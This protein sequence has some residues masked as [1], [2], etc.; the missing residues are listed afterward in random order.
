MVCYTLSKHVKTRSMSNHFLRI[1]R[2]DFKIIDEAFAEDVLY[3]K[4][5]GDFEEDEIMELYDKIS[6]YFLPKEEIKLA[7][8]TLKL[9]GLENMSKSDITPIVNWLQKMYI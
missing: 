6:N 8:I 4:I 9:V 7:M 1:Y 5:I 2:N 3:Y